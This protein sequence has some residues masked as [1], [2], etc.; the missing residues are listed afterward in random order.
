MTDAPYHPC[1]T[2]KDDEPYLFGIDGPGEGLGY[3]AWLLYPQNT[4]PTRAVAEQ[5]ARLMNLAFAEGM[6][7]RSR[8]IK[9]LLND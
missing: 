8:Q 7:A 5:T 2:S 6:K 3:F 9:D 1:S 4:F